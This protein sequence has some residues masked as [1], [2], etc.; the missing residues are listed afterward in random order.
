MNSRKLFP[1][2]SVFAVSTSQPVPPCLLG[3]PIYDIDRPVIA[4]YSKIIVAP[5]QLSRELLMLLYYLIM[6]MPAALLPQLL[7]KASPAFRCG[8]LH[9]YPVTL[10]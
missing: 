10:S 8:F 1:T 7:H 4:A 6:T 2:D 3:V 9:N 5:S